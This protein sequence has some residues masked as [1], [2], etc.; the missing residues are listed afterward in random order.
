MP[1]RPA[2]LVPA[3]RSSVATTALPCESCPVTM[4]RTS[5]AM[6][7]R[8]FDFIGLGRAAFKRP[9]GIIFDREADCGECTYVDERGAV[10][11]PSGVNTA[12]IRTA[13]RRCRRLGR[14]G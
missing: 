12:A 1:A 8:L 5:S 11:R 9:T 10:A 7:F 4:R 13:L 3:R 2:A 14:G 6:A